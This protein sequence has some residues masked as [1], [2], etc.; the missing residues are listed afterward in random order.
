MLQ[1]LAR[2]LLQSYVQEL[3]EKVDEDGNH[4]VVLPENFSEMCRALEED[5]FS[6]PN[7]VLQYMANP[8]SF[9][10]DDITSSQIHEL[11]EG[12]REIRRLDQELAKKIE[13]C[14]VLFFYVCPF[15]LLLLF[16]ALLLVLFF[17]HVSKMYYIIYLFLH[18]EN[19]H[20]GFL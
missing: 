5:H 1:E 18:F 20:A 14:I 4:L 6:T 8:E 10:A 17:F 7:I 9:S 12:L 16:F 19:N 2:A 15:I 11:E 3:L 13:V